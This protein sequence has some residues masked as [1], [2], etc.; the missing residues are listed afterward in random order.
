MIGKIVNF[1][2]WAVLVLFVCNLIYGHMDASSESI[3]EAVSIANQTEDGK[4]LVGDFLKKYTIPSNNEVY[5]LKK[6]SDEIAM[7]D[8]ARKQTGDNSIKTKTEIQIDAETAQN[9]KTSSVAM[10]I[11][12]SK[13]FPFLNISFQQSLAFIFIG[14]L[15]VVFINVFNRRKR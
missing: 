13:P 1:I 5:A 9:E 2:L 6:L 15:I 4:I 11:L 8:I 3:K 12:H 7:R 14:I 10:N